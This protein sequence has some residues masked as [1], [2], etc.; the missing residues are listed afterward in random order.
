MFASIHK[1]VSYVRQRFAADD[2]SRRHFS[3]AFFLGAFTISI[4][5]VPNCSPLFTGYF[6]LIIR[7]RHFGN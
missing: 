6:I 2:F 5:N 7:Q 4:K 3:Y 1:F